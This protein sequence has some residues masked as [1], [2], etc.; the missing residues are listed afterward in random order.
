[1]AGGTCALTG[2]IAHRFGRDSGYLDGCND[3]FNSLITDAGL[4]EAVN[5]R[6]NLLM[7]FATQDQLTDTPEGYKCG[8]IGFMYPIKKDEDEA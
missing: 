6:K 5:D 2:M 8:S 7:N 4:P 3:T 1:M